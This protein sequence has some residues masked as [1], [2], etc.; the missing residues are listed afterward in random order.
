MRAP[1]GSRDLRNADYTVGL[2]TCYRSGSFSGFLRYHHQSSHLGD[3]YLLNSQTAIRRI[4]LSFEELDLKVSF[5][6]TTWLRVY[7]GV[8]RL[9]G[10]DP[11]D[12]KP[13]TSQWGAEFTSPR[14]WMGGKVRPVA[15]VDVQR[16]ERSDWRASRCVMAGLQFEDARI[17]DRKVQLLAEY[18]R[19]PSPNGQFYL[20]ST[21]WFGFG[22]HLYY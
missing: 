21:D 10:R 13:G 14:T 1:S 20:Q 6:P 17:G 2:L 4:N 22:A 7:G 18:F 5:E 3:E 9:V 16:N 12:L 8:G 19:G 15:Y 11:K